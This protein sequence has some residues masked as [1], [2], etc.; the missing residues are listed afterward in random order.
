MLAVFDVLQI[1]NIYTVVSTFLEFLSVLWGWIM[2]LDGNCIK[3]KG[4][5]LP[6]YAVAG[7]GRMKGDQPQ[8]VPVP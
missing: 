5:D 6:L 4:K 3:G 7:H 1:C 8:P 2:F